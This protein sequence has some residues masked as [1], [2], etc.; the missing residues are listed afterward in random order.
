M[1]VC[2]GGNRLWGGG[3]GVGCVWGG[4]QEEKNRLHLVGGGKDGAMWCFRMMGDD[5]QRSL[6]CKA[7]YQKPTYPQAAQR[8]CCGSSSQQSDLR[9]VSPL[10]SHLKAELHAMS[11]GLAG[12]KALGTSQFGWCLQRVIALNCSLAMTTGASLDGQACSYV[13]CYFHCCDRQLVACCCWETQ[14]H[15]RVSSSLE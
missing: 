11:A 13:V 10:T 6:C 7:S 3:R 12:P 2:V 9:G 1:C 15:G 8:C 4:G 14:E 5:K